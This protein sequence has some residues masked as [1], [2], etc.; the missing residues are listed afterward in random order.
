MSVQ[1]IGRIGIHYLVL[2]IPPHPAESAPLMTN[3]AEISNRFERALD[4]TLTPEQLGQRAAHCVEAAEGYIKWFYHHS[5]P[6]M[7]LPDMPIPVSRP[8]E[9]EVLDVQA[10]QEDGELGY[11]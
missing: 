8:P 10:A 1:D 4:H 9:H 2:T 6:H 7:I 3:L 5:H 11:L